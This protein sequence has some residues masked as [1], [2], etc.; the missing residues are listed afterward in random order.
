MSIADVV[1]YQKDYLAH[2]TAMGIPVDQQSAAV[3]AYQMLYP[4]KAAKE[5]GIDM[6][7]KFDQ[8]TQDKL[9]EYYLNMAGQQDYLS[10][11]ITAEQYNDRLAGQFASIKTTSGAG[12]Y[13]NDGLNSAYGTVLDEV[14]AT[15]AKKTK[16]EPV[17]TP[18]TKA[19]LGGRD[20]GLKTGEGLNVGV[21]GTNYRVEKTDDGFR[22]LDGG[23]L[24]AFRQEVNEVPKGLE[25]E[26]INRYGNRPDLNPT[27][28]GEAAADALGSTSADVAAADRAA[29]NGEV[30]VTA[31]MPETKSNESG[32]AGTEVA[33][34]GVNGQG[35]LSTLNSIQLMR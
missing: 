14:R 2:Q 6:S 33:A 11:K 8:A 32:R 7:A 23:F 31:V 17:T 10:G 30:V 28:S 25:E 9:A 27:G 19:F 12:V 34:E 4:D 20:F 5:L 21:G 18:L 13:D 16:P 35:V 29:R 26:F 15:K 1:Q 22:V 24:G 3:G